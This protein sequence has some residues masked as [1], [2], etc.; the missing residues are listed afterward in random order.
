MTKKTKKAKFPFV[1]NEQVKA[2]FRQ[3]VQ[4]KRAIALMTKALADAASDVLDPWEIVK[5][6]HPEVLKQS[7]RLRYN[8]ISETI[9]LDQW[10][11]KRDLM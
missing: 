6:E 8:V 10:R 4:M 1:P 7:S 5:K 9:D 3:E 2:A 11:P